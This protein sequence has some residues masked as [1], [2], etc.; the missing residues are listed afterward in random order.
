MQDNFIKVLFMVLVKWKFHHKVYTK[1][2]GKMV[3]RMDM[4][5]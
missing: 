2:S 4:G 1:D 5:R 3:N